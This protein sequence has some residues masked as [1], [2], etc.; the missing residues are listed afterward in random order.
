MYS[1]FVGGGD[2]DSGWSI[3]LDSEKNVYITGYTR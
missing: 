1:T 2:D 3:A